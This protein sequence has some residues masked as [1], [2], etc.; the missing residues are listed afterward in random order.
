MNLPKNFEWM[1]P[2]KI[3][4][5]PKMIAEG[6]KLLGVKEVPGPTSNPVILQLAKEIGADKIYKNDDTS[7]CAVSHNGVALRAG[8]KVLGYKDPYD[9]LRALAFQK[10]G[11][12]IN[13]SD[14]EV[15]PKDKAMFGDS[16]MFAREGGGHVGMYVAENKT[17]YYVM[18]GNQNN[19]YSF[20]RVAKSR[21]VAVRRPKYNSVPPSVA[22]YF[23]DD[24]DVPV[25]SNEA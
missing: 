8:K 22:K 12:V 3:G 21:L 4:T 17:H 1:D 19:M 6:V 7:W 23:L 5:W 24:A 9:L 2:A 15:V 18:G 13:L 25:T 16:L 20:T 14:W 11:L 10:Q